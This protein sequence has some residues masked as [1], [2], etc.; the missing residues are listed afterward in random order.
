MK[1]GLGGPQSLLSTLSRP[2]LPSEKPPILSRPPN[3]LSLYS[4]FIH[5]PVDPRD[6]IVLV[7]SR[8]PSAEEVCYS[9]GR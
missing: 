3:P 2:L 9:T 1:G 6:F 8:L 7:S 5:R 4:L